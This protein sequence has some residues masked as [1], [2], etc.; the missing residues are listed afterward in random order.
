MDDASD[1]A[2][3]LPIELEEM[4][5]WSV[6]GAGGVDRNSESG[7][8]VAKQ[9]LVV[10]PEDSD[11]H[12]VQNGRFEEGERTRDVNG[13]ARREKGMGMML[14]FRRWEEFIILRRRSATS[15]KRMKFL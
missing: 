15:L 13:G 4:I 14:D 10:G 7:K 3:K 9:I 8:V 6:L 1:F 11:R 2:E 5:R 12:K